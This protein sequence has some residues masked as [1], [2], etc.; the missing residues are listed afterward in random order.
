MR[1]IISQETA[2][3]FLFLQIIFYDAL[4]YGMNLGNDHRIDCS[5]ESLLVVYAVVLFRRP[6]GAYRTLGGEEVSL[7]LHSGNK[8]VYH[9]C[10]RL[11]ETRG[12]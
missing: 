5:K 9:P 6:F 7:A 8:N 4:F 12:T 2:N 3:L 10:A 11:K 1:E